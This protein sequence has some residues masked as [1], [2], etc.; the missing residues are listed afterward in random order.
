MTSVRQTPL[1]SGEFYHVFN[2][3]VARIPMFLSRNDYKQAIQTLYYYRF[4]N[5]P[6]A[7]SRFK[8][9][10]IKEKEIFLNSLQSKDRLIDI[11]SFVLMPNHFHFLLKQLKDNGVS[12]FISQF[13]N[14]YTRHFNTVYERVGPIYQGVFK[15]VHIETDEQ[16][17]HVSR[18]IH[19]N[20]LVSN[21]ISEKDLLSYPWSS[22]PD[23]LNGKSSLV[24]LEYILQQFKSP[25]DYKQFVLDHVDYARKME[26]IKH[27]ILED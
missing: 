21:V 16:L 2:R 9:L 17:V 8:E 26:E 14:S 6:I 3:G 5:P 25:D 10:S 20:P 15:S 7:L 1:V 4:T 24:Q 23:F 19:L 13:T 22:F 18:Y 11:A 27:L 12:K